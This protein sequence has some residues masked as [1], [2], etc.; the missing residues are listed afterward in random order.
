MK[1]YRLI[2]EYPGSLKLGVIVKKKGD[3]HYETI[4][5]KECFHHSAIEGYPEFW[6][7]LEKYK[8][9][10][11]ERWE[12]RVINIVEVCV[13]DENGDTID[14]EI[15]LQYQGEIT[16]G[17]D[18]EVMSIRRGL[19]R[20]QRIEKLILDAIDRLKNDNNVNDEL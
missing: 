14:N 13:V 19:I 15:L 7:E 20:F 16:D 1:K 8:L 17:G 12:E 3:Y 4:D 2:R 10:V 5:E 6:E 11:K 18:K 9:V